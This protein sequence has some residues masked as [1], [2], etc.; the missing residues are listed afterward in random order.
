MLNK[1]QFIFGLV[2][3]I[4]VLGTTL[5]PAAA[6]AEIFAT[7]GIAIHG[8]D[9]VAYFTENRAVDGAAKHALMWMGATWYFASAANMAKFEADPHKFAPQYG[10]YCAYAAS[11]GAVAT[12]V[13]EAFTIHEGKLY[14]NFS[15]GVRSIWRQDIPGN[16]AA[17]DANWP[18]IL[19]K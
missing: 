1:R 15:T 13:P 6:A 2:L 17:A 16:V 18:A 3:A 8:T 7:G 11:K 14:L 12:S 19:A 4:P 9:P 5:R 10:G